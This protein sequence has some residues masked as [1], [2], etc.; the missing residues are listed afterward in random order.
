MAEAALI[1]AEIA[2][3]RD[4]KNDRRNYLSVRRRTGSKPPNALPESLRH[5]LSEFQH[6]GADS[7]SA[8]PSGRDGKRRFGAAD[9]L[10]GH[11]SERF[12]SVNAKRATI[13]SDRRPINA[14]NFQLLDQTEVHPGIGRTDLNLKG[15]DSTA[16]SISPNAATDARAVGFG[17]D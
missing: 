6:M 16:A 1:P 11:W 13:I 15:T 12:G 9:C 10:I 14:I 8:R 2:V 5:R 17:L 7:P 3:E 4:T